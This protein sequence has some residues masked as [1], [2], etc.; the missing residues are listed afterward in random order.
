MRASVDV[1]GERVWMCARFAGLRR[2]AE[3]LNEK[4]EGASPKAKLTK[5]HLF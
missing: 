2:G 5:S 1:K 4:H 3:A